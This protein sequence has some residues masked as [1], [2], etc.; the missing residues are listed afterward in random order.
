MIN[1]RIF[2]NFKNKRVVVMGLG[3][4]GGGVNITKWLFK[5]G[6]KILVTDFKKKNQLL[7]SLKML[8]GLPIKYILGRHRVDDFKNADLIVQNPGVPN[9]SKYLKIAKKYNIP[10]ENEAGIFFKIYPGKIIGITGSRGKS[11][12]SY[13]THLI[14]KNKYK[15]VFLAGNIRIK[16]MFEVVDKLR[17]NDKVILEL[18]SW[19]LEG[20]DKHKIS[21]H[22]SLITNIFP[23]HL[24]R[25]KSY[26][27]YI[28]AKKIIFKY[29]KKNDFCILN[30]DSKACRLMKKG[31]NSKIYWFSKNYQ[32]GLK[33]CFLV[34]DNIIFKN[35]FQKLYICK[36]ND[37]KLLGSH[38]LENVLAS[39]CLA[40]LYK[41]DP[42]LIK[43]AITS[44]SG[45]EDRLEFIRK[46]NQVRFYNDTTATIPEATICALKSFDQRVIL[47]SGGTDKNLNYKSLAQEIKKAVKALILLKGNATDKLKKE[48]I[49]IKYKDLLL[50]TKSID[51]AVKEA[52]K[53][54][55]KNDI[56]LLSPGAASFG[57]FVNEFDR[58]EKF[59]KAVDGLK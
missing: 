9:D 8:R 49:K 27:D 47:I 42:N 58:G 31:V 51:Q 46:F 20:L 29:Q 30:F 19:Q 50:E 11:T 35:G 4:H 32:P 41:I 10:I 44:F 26:E 38:N 56:V 24:N 55:E 52:N 5:K 37:I 54:S 36:K 3:L 12:V 15:N 59:K 48:L 34:K 6:A 23:D 21:P 43:K 22:V 53:V 39:V 57:L 2:L 33:G 17:K 45:L 28:K 1:E 40:C 18:S 7:S 13:L 16:S 14:F 25:Y